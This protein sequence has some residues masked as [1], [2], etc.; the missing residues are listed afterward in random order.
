MQINIISTVLLTATGFYMWPQ[1][2]AG[3]YAAKHEDAFRKNAVVLPI[4]GTL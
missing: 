1:L 4:A 2:F 3:S